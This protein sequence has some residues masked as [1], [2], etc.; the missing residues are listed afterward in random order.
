MKAAFRWML[1][2]LTVAAVYHQHSPAGSVAQA[3]LQPQE[4]HDVGAEVI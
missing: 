2:S 3:E 4:N 1:P